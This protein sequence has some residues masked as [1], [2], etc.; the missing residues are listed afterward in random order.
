MNLNQQFEQFSQ[1]NGFD[2]PE[3]GMQ[4]YNPLKADFF[5]KLIGSDDSQIEPFD[6]LFNESINSQHDDQVKPGFQLEQ[7]MPKP[8][9]LDVSKLSKVLDSSSTNSTATR[10]ATTALSDSVEDVNLDSTV[11]QTLAELE[12]GRGKMAGI[13]FIAQQR[14]RLQQFVCREAQDKFHSIKG[15]M[16]MAL[17]P[18]QLLKMVEKTEYEA[19]SSQQRLSIAIER[20]TQLLID[21]TEPQRAQVAA[22]AINKQLENEVKTIEAYVEAE[23][24]VKEQVTKLANRLD[25]VME[26]TREPYV[27]AASIILDYGDEMTAKKELSKEVLNF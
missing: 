26:K 13:D 3:F 18:E 22:G 19:V 2:R 9:K 12:S 6:D 7:E 20:R 17:A 23:T 24:N 21:S 15:A 11:S 8:I 1:D 16:K 27:Q 4:A 25:Q 14:R 10:R 5:L